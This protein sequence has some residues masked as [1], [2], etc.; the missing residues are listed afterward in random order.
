M[1]SKLFFF[2]SFGPNVGYLSLGNF[3]PL[4]STRLILSINAWKLDYQR[5]LPIFTQD[6]E[7]RNDSLPLTLVSFRGLSERANHTQR[8]AGHRSIAF[9]DKKICSRLRHARESRCGDL[10]RRNDVVEAARLRHRMTISTTNR[11]SN[12]VCS[13]HFRRSIMGQCF[14]KTTRYY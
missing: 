8:K 7:V 12:K 5:L 4:T 11:S 13:L 1:N 2:F 3:S 9:Q 10:S 14:I 6:G